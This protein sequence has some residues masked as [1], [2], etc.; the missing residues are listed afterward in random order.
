MAFRVLALAVSAAVLAAC[1]DAVAPEPVPGAPDQAVP[2]IELLV[3][4]A[5]LELPS[6][7]LTSVPVAVGLFMTVRKS[8]PQPPI[9]PAVV[10][11]RARRLIEDTNEI[12]APCGLHLAVE[13]T[14]VI[15]VQG[16]LIPVQGNIRGSWGGHP[17]DSLGDPDYFMYHQ[18]ERLTGDAVELFGYGKR[19]TMPNAIA[20]F[21]V[22][23]IE[24]YIGD[25]RT[26]AGG[27]SFPPVAFH[28][29]DDYPLRNSV[30]VAATGRD[31]GGLPLASGRVAAHELG[32]MLLN[33]GAHVGIGNL[34][35]GGTLLTAEQCDRMHANRQWLF[36]DGAVPD[37]GPPGIG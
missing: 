12:L 25:Q 27:L 13:A 30:L 17:P 19:H 33:T 20:V 8:V 24:Y 34:M 9:A 16:H 29:A 26:P 3:D 14:Q 32:H 18:N 35:V 11:A 15:A 2:V 21:V 1:G 6:A 22:D 4:V 28:H 37:P 7:P 23:D 5:A 31:L 36:G 10:A